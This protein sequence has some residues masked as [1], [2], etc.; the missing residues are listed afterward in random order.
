MEEVDLVILCLP[1]RGG[2][3]DRRAGRRHGRRRAEGAR[4]LHGASG[5]GRMGLWFSGAEPDQA[6]KIRTARKVSNPGCYPTGG[7][8]DPAA[9]RRRDH[10]G[11]LSGHDQCGE[12]LFGRRQVDDRGPRRRHRAV[13][14][15]LRPRLRAQASAR[16]AALR[17]AHAAADLRAVGR[18]LPPRHAGVGAAAS[19]HAVRQA[20]RAPI[21]T[22]RW[23][24]AMR[25]ANMSRSCRSTT[26]RRKA[27]GS[28][29]RR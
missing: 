4:C 14:R 18:Q 26:K 16:D 13:L 24:S 10:A 15:A 7:G 19:R 11:R 2:A 17:E 23:R 21:C 12:R 28:S 3:G 9:G 5:R 20:E 27:G 22:R 1:D 8:A 25:A 29:R 6:D